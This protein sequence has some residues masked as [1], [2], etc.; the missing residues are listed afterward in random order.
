LTLLVENRTI[1]T[2]LKGS[3][4]CQLMVTILDD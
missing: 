3:S 4:H 2:C 1:N